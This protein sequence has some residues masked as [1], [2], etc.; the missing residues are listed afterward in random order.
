MVATLTL[1]YKDEN[2]VGLSPILDVTAKLGAVVT[3]G[4]EVDLEEGGRLGILVLQGG[5]DSVERA[6]RAIL[7]APC[8]LHGRL[9]A[10]PD[11]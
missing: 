9:A 4:L 10:P 3:P 7:S 1:V 5:R 6:A 2:P 8:I 11:V